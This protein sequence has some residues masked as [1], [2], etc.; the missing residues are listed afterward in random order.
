MRHREKETGREGE[1]ERERK[2][3]TQRDRR[4]HRNKERERELSGIKVLVKQ[5]LGTRIHRYTHYTQ[6]ATTDNT[7]APA[8]PNTHTRHKLQKQPDKTQAHAYSSTHTIQKLQQQIQGQSYKTVS[9]NHN[10]SRERR[11]EA[12][13]NRG[14]SAYQPNA[15]PLGHTG[16]LC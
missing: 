12:E 3:H 6:V 5:V 16:S 10:L 4:T 15:L 7:Q 8:Y 9:T 14:P 2:R 13:S 1:R 11:A